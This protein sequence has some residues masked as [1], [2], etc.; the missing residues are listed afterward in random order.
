MASNAWWRLLAA[1]IAAFWL[2]LLPRAAGAFCRTTTCKVPAD[3]K[4]RID[5][6]YPSNFEDICAARTPPQLVRQLWWRNRCVGYSLNA[7]ASRKI[8]YDD[9]ALVLSEAFSQWTGTSCPSGGSGGGSRVS[10]DVRDLG[11]V[12]CDKV[13]YNTDPNTPNQ[14][15][16][17]FRDSDWPHD[18][19]SN[20]LALTTVNY[21]RDT[22]E[23]YDADMEINS[24]QHRM[25]VEDPVPADGY[26]FLSVMTHET[27]HFLGL[28]HS[29]DSHAVM[30]ASYTPGSTTMRNLT[31]DDIAGICTVYAPNG[32]RSVHESIDGGIVPGEACNPEP[33]HGFSSTCGEKAGCN[34]ATTQPSSGWS[35]VASTFA[36]GLAGLWNRLQRRKASKRA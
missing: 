6:C 26:D 33:R 1:S 13:A 17:L 18:D 15:V 22:G 29:G 12:E 36:V 16:I 23:I 35:F 21:N 27:G 11:P 5:A 4:P 2:L 3:F 25:T 7:A 8:A 9:A 31:T 30:Y 19:A 28:A 34:T 32:D 24:Y 10:V 14:N 20:T